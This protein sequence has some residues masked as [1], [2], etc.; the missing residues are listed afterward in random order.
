[1]DIGYRNEWL[2]LQLDLEEMYFCTIKMCLHIKRLD[3]FDF[4]YIYNATDLCV[5]EWNRE[6]LFFL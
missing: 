5:N 6:G 1:M 2:R 3:C 4:D